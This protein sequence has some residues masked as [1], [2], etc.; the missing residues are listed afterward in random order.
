M[1]GS[2]AESDSGKDGP[3]AAAF[4]NVDADSAY[5]AR[6]PPSPAAPAARVTTSLPK[7]S[8]IGPASAKRDLA[9]AIRAAESGKVA[10]RLSVAAVIAQF[11]ARAATAKLM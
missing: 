4:K 3:S 6:M 7:T 2:E 8:A 5:F 1:Q 10:A 11:A 9:A